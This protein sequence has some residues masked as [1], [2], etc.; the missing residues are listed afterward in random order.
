M[1]KYP[2]TPYATELN[3]ESLLRTA[4]TF[5]AVADGGRWKEG[6]D[7]ASSMPVRS[8]TRV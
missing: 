8:C 7:V 3:K 5:T 6:N 2:Y 1:E 4:A